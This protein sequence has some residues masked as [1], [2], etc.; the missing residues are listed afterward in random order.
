MQGAGTG[1]VIIGVLRVLSGIAANNDGAAAV[2]YL[3]E[4]APQAPSMYTSLV[5]CAMAAGALGATVFASA[6]AWLLSGVKL[7]VFGWRLALVGSLVAHGVSGFLRGYV[8][9]DPEQRMSSAE[10][11]DRRNAHVRKV[12]RYAIDSLHV[13]NESL[14][15]LVTRRLIDA[16]GGHCV[17]RMLSCCRA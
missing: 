14:D 6:M 4:H 16:S 7:G 13:I 2:A 9:Q 10:L 8:L 3:A 11:S 17:Q 15:S 12:I 5:P 1:L